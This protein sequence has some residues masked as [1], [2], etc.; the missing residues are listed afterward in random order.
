MQ[1]LASLGPQALPPVEASMNRIPALWSIVWQYRHTHENRRRRSENWRATDFRTWRL[2]RYLAN[3]S[4]IAQQPLGD[5][6]G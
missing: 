3:N 6:K 2:Q 5:D 1:Y 4:G